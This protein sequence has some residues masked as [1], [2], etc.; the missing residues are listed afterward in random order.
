MIPLAACNEKIN[1]CL[2]ELKCVAYSPERKL[3]F[4]GGKGLNEIVAYN[5]EHK[6]EWEAESGI[7]VVYA[8]QW[9]SEMSVLLAAGIKEI[10]LI[11]PCDGALQ[12]SMA[13]G[14]YDVRCFCWCSQLGTAII[15]GSYERFVIGMIVSV[16][17]RIN[18]PVWAIKGDKIGAT[19][20]GV[21]AMCLDTD[22]SKLFCGGNNSKVVCLEPSTSKRLWTSDVQVG[23]RAAF[24]SRFHG[25]TALQWADMARVVIAAGDKGKMAA[26]DPDTGDT[27]WVVA[28]G[29]GRI[30][31]LAYVPDLRM[32][33]C[34]GDYVDTGTQDPFA[35]THVIEDH[36]EA[37][38]SSHDVVA[39]VT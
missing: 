33:V 32:T 19:T 27:V 29:I 36:V 15:G 7:S 6:M 38:S 37:A 10:A 5:T 31:H 23:Q 3:L 21:K 18:E 9:S 34:S 2:Q 1:T 16:E 8:L 39:L 12:W 17:P 35:T 4:A 30:W 22:Q 28:T 20:G 11:D 26:L 14:F 13:A 25:V 24:G